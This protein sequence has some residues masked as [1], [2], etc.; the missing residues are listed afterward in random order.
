MWFTIISFGVTK[1]CCQRNFKHMQCLP[2][3]ISLLRG[4]F[5]LQSESDVS[6]GLKSIIRNTQNNL[7]FMSHFNMNPG[8]LKKRQK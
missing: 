3:K 1:A 5:V 7:L 6:C 4:L 2:A 8:R